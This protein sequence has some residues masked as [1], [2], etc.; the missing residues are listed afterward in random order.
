MNRKKC[1][2]LCVG[3]ELLLGD[4]L[5]TNAQFLAQRLSL[6]GLDVYVQ[7]VVGDNEIRLEQAVKAAMQRA[8][9]LL[10]T[11]GL[12]PTQDDLTKEVVARC[13]DTRL[14]LDQEVLEGIR[15]FYAVSARTMPKSNEKQALMPE[16]GIV[17]TNSQGTAPG[18]IMYSEDGHI[19]I[20]MPGPPREVEPMFDQSVFPFLHQFSTS[21]L[22][23]RLVKVISLGESR[24]AE[25]LQDLLENGQNP[26]LAPYAK[27]GEA[28]VRLTARAHSRQE[29]DKLMEP[30][31]SEIRKRL[32]RHVYG[33]DV[34]NI[35]TVVAQLLSHQGIRLSFIEAG[36]AG[37]AARRLQA[38]DL[39]Q[40]VCGPSVSAPGLQG[41]STLLE[42]DFSGNNLADTCLKLTETAQKHLHTDMA[43]AIVLDNKQYACAVKFG[44]VTRQTTQNLPD[45]S[46]DYHC[47]LAVQAALNMVRHLLLDLQEEAE[48]PQ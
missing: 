34:P 45:R 23:S 11:G 43:A 46:R 26:T 2:I 47:T 15:Q 8:D 19:A 22:Y 6:L 48:A 39:A 9:I 24:M 25:M 16:G 7:T 37:Q 32:G 18:C 17:L 14:T 4:I 38:T 28:M 33:I 31:M 13:F 21:G 44:A 35:E 3:T 42:D 36:S 30:I 12:G 10:F 20:L 29:A 5:N 40:D 41:L 1:E 27:D